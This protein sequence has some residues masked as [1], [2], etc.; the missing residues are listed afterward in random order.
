MKR[1]FSCLDD[2]LKIKDIRIAE[3]DFGEKII[4]KKDARL[5]TRAAKDLGYDYAEALGHVEPDAAYF[6]QAN[7][8]LTKLYGEYSP[9]KLSQRVF[10]SKGKKY[11]YTVYQLTVNGK[12]KTL[13][14]ARFQW[15]VAHPTETIPDD[16]DIVRIDGDPLND[17]PSNL[18]CV[19]RKDAV[20]K[21]N[22]GRP[23]KKQ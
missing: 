12:Q 20:A 8:Y 10:K 21:R 22:V 11:Y 6:K 3:N 9:L 13:T 1:N 2:L 23:L 19:S 5:R 4:V 14:N 15:L 16:Y 17:D 7:D 18:R